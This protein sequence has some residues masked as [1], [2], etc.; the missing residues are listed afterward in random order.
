M[1]I[2]GFVLFAATVVVAAALIVQNPATVAVHAFN[3]LWNVDMRWVVVAGLALTALGLF[4]LGMMRRGSAR[5]LRLRGERR[6]LMAENKRLIKR[7]AATAPAGTG[8]DT[9][10]RTAPAAKPREPVPAAPSSDRPGFLE[11]LVPTR[12]R[13]VPS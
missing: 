10:P 4:G 5:H 1:I 2:V 7:T 13:R 11:R 3:Q 8:R 12:H 6:A 9:T